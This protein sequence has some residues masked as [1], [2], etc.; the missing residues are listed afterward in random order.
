MEFASAYVSLGDKP[1]TIEWLNK[2]YEEE[3]FGLMFLN[4]E[5]HWDG[6]RSDPNFQRLLRRINQYDA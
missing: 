3:S 1:Q 6:F 2:A 5:S 4:F